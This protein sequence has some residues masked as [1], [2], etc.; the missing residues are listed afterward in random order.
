MP[1]D[2]SS[3]P[4]LVKLQ[5][6][7]L[8]RAGFHHTCALRQ[9]GTLWC[10]GF[11]NLGQLGDGSTTD[12]STPV[13]VGSLTDV[14]DIALN[15]FDAY[16]PLAHTCARQSDG[17]LSCWG[18]NQ[19]GELGD[20]ATAPKATPTR[21]PEFADAVALGVG[22]KHSCTVRLGGTVW[23][24]GA[25]DKGQLGDGGRVDSP[26]PVRVALHCP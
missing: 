8:I 11:N 3:A 17:A 7:I 9:D 4:V 2:H 14:V 12:R 18:A 5:D 20:G 16:G 13:R 26:V 22:A 15:G 6:V 10:W 21:V 24:W 1:V 25:D 19:F 23:C